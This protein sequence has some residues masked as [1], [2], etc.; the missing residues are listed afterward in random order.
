MIKIK[1]MIRSMKTQPCLFV[2]HV[3]EDFQRVPVFNQQPHHL[4]V[5]VQT[6]DGIGQNFLQHAWDTSSR[7]ARDP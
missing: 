6:D 1:M 7:Q 5:V 2:S 3:H 4:G